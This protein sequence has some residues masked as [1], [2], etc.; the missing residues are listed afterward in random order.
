MGFF[1]K[2]N[3]IACKAEVGLNRHMIKGGDLCPNC[4]SKYRDGFLGIFRSIDEVLKNS[5]IGRLELEQKEKNKAAEK[6][7]SDPNLNSME[8][9][10]F[11][12][13]ISAESGMNLNDVDSYLDSIP[14]D[15][16]N[17]LIMSFKINNQKTNDKNNS[18][19]PTINVIQPDSNQPQCP[20]CSSRETTHN[21]QGFGVGKAAVGALLT[22]GIGLLAGGI[23]K[24]K[25]KITCLK[26]GYSWN[27]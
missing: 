4:Y 20:K 27:P 3:C 24:N 13:Y 19:S 25:I 9:L 6:A 23:N 18:T 2:K 1:D 12:K 5:K 15:E 8:K 10:Q 14:I 11:R 22:G 21:K 26:C 7:I 17:E 16:K